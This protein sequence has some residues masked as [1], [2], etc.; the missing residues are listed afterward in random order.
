[1]TT[2]SSQGAATR[3]AMNGY[4]IPFIKIGDETVQ[5]LIDDGE[6]VITGLM[7]ALAGRVSI[8]PTTVRVP[9]RLH[10][11][12]KELTV[13]FPLMGLSLSS[14]L[15][16]P[17]ESLDD[18]T[19][20]IDRV[21]S[22]DT[23]ANCK[24]DTW[25]LSG[26]MGAQP[27]Q[28]DLIVVGKT[29]TPAYPGSFS[30]TA[31][32]TDGPYPFAGCETLSLRSSSRKGNAIAMT[33]QH[34]LQSQFENQLTANCIDMTHR[35]VTLAS[36]FPWI[37]GI[38]DLQSGPIADANGA[39]ATLLFTKGG[40]STSIALFNIKE[41]V[42]PPQIPGKVALRLPYFARAYRDASDYVFQITHDDT[43]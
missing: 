5:G 29:W 10:P 36:S 20:L 27:M 18:F 41:I 9:I 13:L 34:H 8:G 32:Q 39:A 37:S 25:T 43:P 28:L 38:T 1:M 3:L 33:V 21:A 15:W 19:M 14:G 40:Q 23:Y 42:R 35:T 7:D 4:Q 26:Q 16:L 6:D 22:V 24:I 11:T 30:A 31:L 17:Q 2:C 12:P